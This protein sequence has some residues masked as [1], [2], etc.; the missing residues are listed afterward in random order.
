MTK[1]NTD[2]Q[3]AREPQ[4][5]DGIGHHEALNRV[6]E[7]KQHEPRINSSAVL[8]DST[9]TALEAAHSARAWRATRARASTSGRCT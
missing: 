2:Q 6:R 8:T 5:P 3:R 1:P 4:Q 7:D 9:L